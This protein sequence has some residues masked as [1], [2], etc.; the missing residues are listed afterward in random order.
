MKVFRE[1]ELQNFLKVCLNNLNQ[2]VQSE[3]RKT[4]SNLY[5]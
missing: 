1:I 2:E 4:W 5:S 3:N